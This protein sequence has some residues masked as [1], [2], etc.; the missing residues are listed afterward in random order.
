MQ[1]ILKQAQTLHQ[2]GK[3]SEAE[4][5]YRKLLEADATNPLFNSRLALLLS[6]TQR[7]Q[8]AFA[9]ISKA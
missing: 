9:Y 3:L 4:A 8:E 6:Q 7:T 2:Q 1:A 5:G